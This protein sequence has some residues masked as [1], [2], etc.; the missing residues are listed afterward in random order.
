LIEENRRLNTGM[1]TKHD[2][3]SVQNTVLLTKIETLEWQLKQVQF[4]FIADFYKNKKY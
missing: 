3:S 2:K 4:N 1:D